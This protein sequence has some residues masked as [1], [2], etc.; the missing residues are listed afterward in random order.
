M[1]LLNKKYY[2]RRAEL[3]YLWEFGIFRGRRP[4]TVTFMQ[5][6]DAKKLAD[7]QG[8]FFKGHWRG[9]VKMSALCIVKVTFWQCW[10]SLIWAPLLNTNHGHKRNR[11]TQRCTGKKHHYLI[12]F[13][14]FTLKDIYCENICC[15]KK[16]STVFCG[17]QK[18][19]SRK[20][21][22]S[23]RY[24]QQDIDLSNLFVPRTANW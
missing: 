16:I 4:W 20:Y 9:R 15:E 8:K 22:I 23:G 11:C 5:Y 17:R 3:L 14:V 7:C 21:L 2:E 12:I 19:P 13:T 10:Y 6:F 18:P 1:S 24:S